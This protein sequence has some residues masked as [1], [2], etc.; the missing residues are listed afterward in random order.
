[1]PAG[2]AAFFGAAPGACPFHFFNRR[3]ALASRQIHGR[4]LPRFV[5]TAIVAAL[6]NG[7]IVGVSSTAGLYF[8][9]AQVIATGAILV[10]KFFVSKPWIFS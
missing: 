7:A 6:L 8:L 4:A 9:L 1:M 10:L 5:P 2:R 3:P